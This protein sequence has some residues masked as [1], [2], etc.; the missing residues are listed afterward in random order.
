LAGTTT[1]VPLRDL[2]TKGIHL[3]GSM[4]RNRT[5]EMKARILSELVTRSGPSWSRA[6]S[7]RL[8]TAFCRSKRPRRRTPVLEQS[9]NVGKVVL[10]VRG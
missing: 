3:V 5:P 8:S 2:L 4:L 7:A 9:H 6:K 10:A 1:E